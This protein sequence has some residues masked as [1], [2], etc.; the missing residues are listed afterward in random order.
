MMDLRIPDA[1]SSTVTM[2]EYQSYEFIAIDRPLTSKQ[3]AELRVVSTRAE[4]SPTRFWNEYQWGDL[5]AD[6][7]K[8]VGAV[9]ERATPLA[10]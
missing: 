10:H 7:A 4:I 5:K 6:P 9:R 8:L 2:S 1:R 3:M